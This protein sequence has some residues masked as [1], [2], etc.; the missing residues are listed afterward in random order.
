MSMPAKI[1]ISLA[2]GIVTVI[3]VLAFSLLQRSPATQDARTVGGDGGPLCIGE[4]VTLQE[5][6][7]EEPFTVLIPDPDAK[8]G[9]SIAEV[10]QVSKGGSE[11][12]SEHGV[13]MR[14]DSGVVIREWTPPDT[15][16]DPLKTWRSILEAY[17]DE[18]YSIGSV[19]GT[20][21]CSS[22][23]I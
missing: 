12:G 20:P 4:D 15:A 16:D 19:S 5:A 7:A 22:S 8:A 3:V 14:L 1:R 11:P 13:V 10:C 23:R 21:P 6:S 18:G 17:P 9:G 2:V